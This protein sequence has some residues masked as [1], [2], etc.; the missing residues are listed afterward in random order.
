MAVRLPRWRVVGRRI[1]AV[2]DLL[3]GLR[4]EAILSPLDARVSERVSTG[5][6]SVELATWFR[7]QDSGSVPWLGASTRWTVIQC[8]LLWSTL[9]SALVP[10]AW[11]AVR[12]LTTPELAL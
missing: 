8:E 7:E 12:N 3:N 6:V 4:G 9:P 5:L 10:R 2:A 1:T 11:A